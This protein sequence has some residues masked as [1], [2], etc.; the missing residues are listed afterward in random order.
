MIIVHAPL[1]MSFGG[2]GTDLEAYYAPFGGFVVNAT[3]AHYCS[4]L[5]R[6]SLDGRN[7]IIS[8]DYQITESFECGMT[9][10]V[11]GPLALAK[12]ALAWFTDRGLCTNG[13]EL[14]LAADVP[15]G[16]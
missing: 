15:P 16:T 2:G 9:P 5:A 7:R 13:V 1:R 4:V 8:L 6:E 12:A 3:I 10:A 11:T 14:V